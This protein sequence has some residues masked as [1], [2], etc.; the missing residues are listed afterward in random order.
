MASIGR[1]LKITGLFCKTA[2]YKRLCSAKE[3]YNFEEPSN[4]S[5]PTGL[6]SG[7]LELL[8]KI[9]LG[10]VGSSRETC[11]AGVEYHFQEFNEPYAPS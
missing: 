8:A 3:T 11:G 7:L 2:L 9:S 10:H 1:L 6:V 5:H 4:G